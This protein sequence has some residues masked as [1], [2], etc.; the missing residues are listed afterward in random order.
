[1]AFAAKQ[2]AQQMRAF[3]HAQRSVLPQGCVPQALTH[4]AAS[5]GAI[6]TLIRMVSPEAIG[7]F[8]KMLRFTHIVNDHVHELVGAT[9]QQDLS[10]LS[11]LDI[12]PEDLGKA[13][14]E[15]QIIAA[16]GEAFVHQISTWMCELSPTNLGLAAD[17]VLQ[18]SIGGLE[19]ALRVFSCEGL[20]QIL[21]ILSCASIKVDDLRKVGASL[22]AGPDISEQS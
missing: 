15:L 19:E 9:M 16:E 4:A 14:T 5:L 8:P 7:G 21:T 18:A 10:Y 20:S 12:P 2:A 1:M 3:L 11:Y 22:T 13:Q 17:R 6:L